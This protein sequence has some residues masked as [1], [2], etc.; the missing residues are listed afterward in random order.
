M[1]LLTGNLALRGPEVERGG[2]N[3]ELAREIFNREQHGFPNRGRL[4]TPPHPRLALASARQRLMWWLSS[5]GEHRAG[6]SE[7]LRSRRCDARRPAP[8]IQPCPW[9]AGGGQGL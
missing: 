6:P 8:R 9:W 7:A 3:V 5:A 4:T 1:D 2:L